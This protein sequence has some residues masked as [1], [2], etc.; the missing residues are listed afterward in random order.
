MSLNFNALAA[1][2]W[3]YRPAP[4]VVWLLLLTLAVL[5]LYVFV[6]RP[7]IVQQVEARAALLLQHSTIT[8][9]AQQVP[10]TAQKNLLAQLHWRESQ[11]AQV[12]WQQAIIDQMQQ[13]QQQVNGL[14]ASYAL[15]SQQT[16]PLH[17][18]TYA[19]QRIDLDI[20]PTHDQQLW[21]FLA[22]LQRNL[23]GVSVLSQL[24]VNNENAG[25]LQATA[26]LVIYRLVTP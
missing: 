26:T 23:P 20:T 25:R 22:L 18:D 9:Q 16:V 24:Q 2:G 17:D 21:Q 1:R 13:T 11:N 15:A 6:L 12:S 7:A 19:V 4:Y 10:S 3:R 5:A 8:T 14:T